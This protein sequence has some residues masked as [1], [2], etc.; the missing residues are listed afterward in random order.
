MQ[1]SF[2]SHKSIVDMAPCAV[3]AICNDRIIYAN[4][5]MGALAGATPDGLC[6]APLTEV[7]DIDPQAL[8]RLLRQ[9]ASTGRAAF[10][11][12]PRRRESF[13][14]R[15]A[16]F[17]GQPG[18]LLY[19]Q[20]CAEADPSEQS[21][22]L[23]QREQTLKLH[24]KL[25][26]ARKQITKAGKIKDD[27]I[28]HMS[29][30]MRTPLNGIIGVASLLQQTTLSADQ[31]WY[32]DMIT[33]SSETLLGL[34]SDVLDYARLEAGAM[35]ADS[36]PFDVHDIVY[37][38]TG[39]L[40]AEAYRKGLEMSCDIDP[41]IP[42]T[43]IS[44]Q[45]HIRRLLVNLLSNAVK[46]TCQGSIT[47]HVDMESWKESTATLHCTVRDT[48]KGI[49]DNKL[50]AIFD[51]FAQ[52]DS[53]IS[54]QYGGTGLG[55]AIC[56]KLMEIHKGRIWVESELGKGSAFHFALPCGVASK[57][58]GPKPRAKSSKPWLLIYQQTSIA[59]PIIKRYLDF[60]GYRY[61]ES[62]NSMAALTIGSRFAGV[63]FDYVDAD[64]II[65]DTFAQIRH[66]LNNTLILACSPVRYASLRQDA[67][68]R[69]IRLAPKPIVPDTLRDLMKG[70]PG[71]TAS[72]S[73]AASSPP[74]SD[75][76]AGSGK[77]ILVVEDNEINQIFIQRALS[78]HG[79]EL[80]LAN[81]GREA[82]ELAQS[83]K[84]DIILMDVQMPVMD[85]LEATRTIRAM[86]SGTNADTV[87]V[88]LTAGTNP[89]EKDACAQAGM[90]GFLPKPISTPQLVRKTA[91]YLSGDAT[92]AFI[93]TSPVSLASNENNDA[94][95]KALD[96]LSG[97]VELFSELL[98]IVV[99]RWDALIESA[100]TCYEARNPEALG[101]TLHTMKGSV[102]V[103]EKKGFVS[104][105]ASLIERC[106]AG[107]IPPR[108]RT[109]KLLGD[110]RDYLYMLQDAARKKNA[111]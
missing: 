34:V 100:Q 43:L 4:E 56:K 101:K 33:Q 18:Y 67:R 47:L 44:D 16:D 105:M 109:M 5:A 77:R 72:A 76:Q 68:F 94:Y 65:P 1:Q 55:L 7:C 41:R 107:D 57:K 39:G 90:N 35:E 111:A 85:G 17:S 6:D 37:S 80:E 48:G 62:H 78:Q 32:V 71:E 25:A 66:K 82:C 30:E 75:K 28:A 99:G 63:I 12:H 87:I 21:Q 23:A 54:N 22:S 108:S 51:H 52:E 81:N 9:R 86:E 83:R 29:H 13:I 104:D 27:F 50:K 102:N 73:L 79:Y 2:D 3:C 26:L 61:K 103:F 58:T 93:Q 46:F 95:R 53:T 70:E 24:R 42:R 96:A 97:D 110:Q 98:G 106:R 88:A 36:A 11:R 45:S 8:P 64:D 20:D 14:V 31:K 92:D 38:I 74:A 49:A 19:F 15:T 10:R 40:A 59:M 84:F 89:K 91:D 60:W 69:G